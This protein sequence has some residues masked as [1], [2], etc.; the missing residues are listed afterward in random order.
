[1]KVI[2][3]KY[4]INLLIKNKVTKALL[5]HPKDHSIIQKKSKFNSHSKNL[6]SSKVFLGRSVASFFNN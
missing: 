1:M 4:K 6:M 2:R 5:L 3:L